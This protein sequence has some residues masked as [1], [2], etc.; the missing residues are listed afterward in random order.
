MYHMKIGF[1]VV[2]S[3]ELTKSYG[4]IHHFLMGKS[5]LFRLG[6]VQ[7]QTVSSPEGIFFVLEVSVGQVG[8][9]FFF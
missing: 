8:F 2:P 6:H 3:G 4:K 5:S 1:Q 9:M 7:L